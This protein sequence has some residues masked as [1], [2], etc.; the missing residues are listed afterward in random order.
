MVDS[1]EIKQIDEQAAKKSNN[2]DADS[3]TTADSN[4]P[5]R[6]RKAAAELAGQ[7]QIK[8]AADLYRKVMQGYAASGKILSAI[9]TKALELKISRRASTNAR[10]IYDALRSIAANN[11]PSYE[12][13]T[14]MSYDELLSILQTFEV[15]VFPPNS[16]VKKPGE[17][18][19][20]L[21]FVISGTLQETIVQEGQENPENRV[22]LIENAF[23]GD[24][25]PFEEDKVCNSMLMSVTEVELLKIA[26]T[27]L[28]R[29]AQKKCNFEFLC[30]ELLSTRYDIGGRRS[31][32]IVRATQRYQLLTR[33]DIKI[34]SDVPNEKPLVLNGFTEDLSL[35]GACICLSASYLSGAT[36]LVGKKVI[37]ALRVAKL[38]TGVDVPGTIAWKR[39]VNRGKSKDIVI[40]IQFKDIP[41]ADFEFIKRHCYIGDGAEQMIYSLWQSCVTK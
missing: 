33:V 27:D 40:G 29:L 20:D 6:M 5:M 31:K 11:I 12:F 3:L 2:A 14:K 39:E 19:T 37:L 22:T 26:K 7:K 38:L 18:E 17:P 1:Q 32:Q 21:Y 16:I 8:Q 10:D 28:I 4:D 34:L 24:I 13:F 23:T 9:A 41:S 30:M 25:Y 15:E 36:N 35:G